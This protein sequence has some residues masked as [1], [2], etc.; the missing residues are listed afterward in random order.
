MA[1][2]EQGRYC[3]ACSKTVID[4]TNY[5]DQEIADYFIALNGQGV[6]GHFKK[7]Q[8]DRIRIEIPET[9]LSIRLPKWKKFLVICMLV[10]GTSVFPFEAALS[11][12]LIASTTTEPV[13]NQQK[14]KPAKKSKKKKQEIIFNLSEILIVP[15]FHLDGYTTIRPSSS[16]FM[17]SEMY[18]ACIY[19]LTSATGMKNSTI[20][21]SSI[22][23]DDKTPKTPSKKESQFYILPRPIGIRRSR[24]KKP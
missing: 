20:E 10:F 2:N 7:Q 17:T 1:P 18:K 4:F 13:K 6:C 24:R 3:S 8:V 19:P 21:E 23:G 12:T 16:T 9:I 15:N 22:P 14:K 11:Q 5:S